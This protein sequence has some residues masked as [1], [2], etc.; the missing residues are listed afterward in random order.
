MREH[1]WPF[2][3]AAHLAL[4]LIEQT[5]SIIEAYAP[6]FASDEGKTFSIYTFS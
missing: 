2:F 5:R 3:L 4:D 6:G 1:L